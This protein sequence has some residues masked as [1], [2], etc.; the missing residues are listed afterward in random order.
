MPPSGPP[1]HVL[2]SE[3]K[4]VQKLREL[5]GD[6]A[7]VLE[8]GCNDGM[9]TRLFLETYRD[10]NFAIYCF[11]P[12]PRPL[13]RFYRQVHDARVRGPFQLAIAD[14]TGFT[15]LN[16]SSGQNANS[17]VPDWDLS[18][19]IHKPKEHLKRSPWIKFDKQLT[20]RCAR[21][22]EWL[23]CRDEI[24][25]IDLVWADVQGAEGDMLR[26]GAETFRKR[27]RLIYTEFYEVEMYEG[28]LN[29]AGI[30]ALLPSFQILETFGD[31]V[32]LKNTILP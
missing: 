10:P 24:G 25:R 5:T 32:L 20:V 14:Q 22:D 8:I 28:Q 23:E 4:I 7:T 21:L 19:S 30:Q 29:L 27:V 2:A 18:S 6:P 12:D 26:G 13:E 9:H 16:L 11:D 1:G 17:W 3:R 15:E 31:N